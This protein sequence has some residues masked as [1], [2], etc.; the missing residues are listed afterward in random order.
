M[1]DELLDEETEED[2]EPP[3]HEGAPEPAP[4][5]T[6][7]DLL[8]IG[9]AMAG[10]LV[11]F[12]VGFIS[13][14]AIADDGDGID[15]ARAKS[16]ICQNRKPVPTAGPS[17][18]P[19]TRSETRRDLDEEPPLLIELRSYENGKTSYLRLGT[20]E[21]LPSREVTVMNLWATWCKPCVS[22]LPVFKALFERH[23]DWKGK[24]AFL[25]VLTEDP[26]PTEIAFRDFKGLMPPLRGFLV[27]FGGF[28]DSLKKKQLWRGDLPVTF[29][30]GCRQKIR[31]ARFG[32]IDGPA[33]EELEATVA[34]L[35]ADLDSAECQKDVAVCG[36]GRC[37]GLENKVTC[38]Q[39]CPADMVICGDTV[40]DG[41]GESK[42]SCP[43]DC[44]CGD[45]T[46]GE[47]E[48]FR[49]CKKDCR[50][51]CPRDRKCGSGYECDSKGRCMNEYG[52]EQPW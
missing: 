17:V 38:K 26:S 6:V 12:G 37:N 35:M 40:C 14:R 2:E 3:H 45:G 24:A 47:G 50:P 13:L 22:E 27:E 9:G 11:C 34:K 16:A 49:N 31:W 46:C 30:V 1:T 44:R 43:Q 18:E 23:P 42:E 7:W 32:E 41:P 10:S 28:T 48:T 25:P 21:A 19:P 39:D 20:K 52:Y 15:T 4:G 33:L 29:V 5:P 8:L 51:V 36:D